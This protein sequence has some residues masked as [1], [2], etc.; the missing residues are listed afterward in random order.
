[1]V[2]EEKKIQEV[3]FK[4]TAEGTAG[5]KFIPFLIDAS[6]QLL[7]PHTCARMYMCHLL[8]LVSESVP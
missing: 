7:H 4:L 2:R 8:V 1:M 3:T 5:D 6:A